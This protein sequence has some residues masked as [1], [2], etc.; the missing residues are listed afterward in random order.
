[1]RHPEGIRDEVAHA[2]LASA[3]GIDIAAVYGRSADAAADLAASY[4]ATA[5]HDLSAFLAGVDAVA[6]A[7]AARCPL[8]ESIL[9]RPN[10]VGPRTHLLTG[11]KAG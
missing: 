10:Q 11:H 1:V 2:P 3:D 8:G 9:I 5:Q 7:P 4:R 6:F